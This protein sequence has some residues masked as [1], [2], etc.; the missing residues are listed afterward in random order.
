MLFEK[1]EVLVID[2]DEDDFFLVS[3]LLSDISGVHFKVSWEPDYERALEKIHKQCYE[4]YIIDF[5]L[6]KM[7]GLD[8]LQEAVKVNRRKPVIM[9]TGQGQ[10]E[11]DY[12]A[13]QLGAADY[14]IK[15]DIT[16]QAIERSIR[17]A[18]S[19]A[20][21]MDKIYHQEK[22]YRALFEHSL[23]A[24]FITGQDLIFI[25][26]NPV[27][28]K[29]FG[30]SLV[31]FEKKHLRELFSHDADYLRFSQL[32]E[33]QKQVKNLEAN[34][35]CKRSREFTGSISATQFIDYEGGIKRYQGIIE[36]I[37]ERK[38]LQT[39]LIQLEKLIMT[40]NIARSIAHEVRN[41]LT[42]INLALEQFG[43]DANPIEED[44]MK[45]YLDII[46]RNTTRINQL[47]TEMLRSSKPSQLQK[48]EYQLNEVV[49]SALK[50]AEDRIK[51]QEVKIIKLY[52]KKLPPLE[53]DKAKLGIAFL[54]IITNALEAVTPREGVITVQTRLKGEHQSV[55]ICDNG[56]G[57]NESELAK[58]FD[59]FHTSKKS[60]MGLGL[61]STQNIIN[62]HGGRI[63]VDSTPGKGTC[64]TLFFPQEN[65]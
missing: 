7:N 39:E 35:V 10:P 33:K 34:F 23:S 43:S 15:G 29:Q 60:G 45:I 54:N 51:L 57:I 5:M 53:I 59:A 19:N 13:M 49:E 48:H 44:E 31:E 63:S 28:L 64:F 40:G 9:L 62:S 26:A 14:L 47:I 21:A 1:V 30:Y 52:D 25:D 42:N 6:G 32:M 58:L 61:T 12:Q 41:P 65:S 11:I 55:C 46:R 4:I 37:S 50:L 22:K 17:Y 36:D 16:A 2:D 27:M 3:D 20:R 8:L 24:T 18:L 38:K 56:P